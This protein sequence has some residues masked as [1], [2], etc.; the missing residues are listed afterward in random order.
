MRKFSAN[1]YEIKLPYDIGICPI[2]NVADLYI[3]KD[4]GTDDRPEDR[5]KIDWVKQLPTRKPL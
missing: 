2:F 4:S 1:A 3:Y 5:E